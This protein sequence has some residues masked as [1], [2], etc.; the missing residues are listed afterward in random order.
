MILRPDDFAGWRINWDDKA[1]N[2]SQLVRELNLGLDSVVF[3]DDNPAERARIRE[4]FPEVLVPELPED[5]R[6]YVQTLLALDCFNKPDVTGEDRQRVR[7]YAEERQ[8]TEIRNVATSTDEWL[9]SLKMVITASRLNKSNLTRVTQLLNKTNQMNL[10]TRRLSEIEYAQWSSAA[11]RMVWAFRV[12]DRLGDSGLVGILGVEAE[13]SRAMIVDFVLSCRAMGRRVE[14][15]MLHV[16]VEWARQSGLKEVQAT[17]RPTAKN[18]PCLEFFR[19][20][21]F[22]ERAT[23][24]FVWDTAAAYPAVP[25][26]SLVLDKDDMPM[27]QPASSRQ[28]TESK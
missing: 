21:A 23:D 22:R 28:T 17:Y 9:A 7:M 8:R 20:N 25:A 4:S 2:L 3:L 14:E 27:E 16:A 11:R 10:S 12:E 24:E 18:Q 1:Q 26:I 5:K 13:G 6:L 19:R 15:T